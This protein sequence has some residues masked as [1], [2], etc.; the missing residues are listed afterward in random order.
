MSKHRSYILIL[1]SVIHVR[2][3]NNSSFLSLALL[4]RRRLAVL[5]V[6]LALAH[7]RAD[8]DLLA[9]RVV[10]LIHIDVKLRKVFVVKLL[11]VL[12][13]V[14]LCKSLVEVFKAAYEY[15]L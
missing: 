9:L 3:D 15:A 12:F 10:V 8:I 14:L 11:A 4:L 7:Q 1:N 2:A 6:L 5:L 13:E